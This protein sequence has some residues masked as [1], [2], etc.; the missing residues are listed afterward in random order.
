MKKR[1]ILLL[2]SLLLVSHSSI[3]YADFN[4]GDAVLSDIVTI[5]TEQEVDPDF[6]SGDEEVLADHDVSADDEEVP[7]DNGASVD[8]E[9]ISDDTTDVPSEESDVS[10]S[11]D[12]N[13]FSTGEDPVDD[14]SAELYEANESKYT[15]SFEVKGVFG[16]RNVTFNTNAPDGA[17]IYYSSTT[18]TLTTKDACVT[19]GETVLFEDFYGTIYART[20]VNGTWGTVSRL[21]LRIPVV[22]D[23]EIQVNGA[24]VTITTPTPQCFIYYTT[25]GTTPSLTNGTRASGSK[26][27]F[28]V[29]ANTTVKA[30]AVRSCFTNSNVV[31][32]KIQL[33][34]PAF[35]VKGIFG[36]RNVTFSCND[37]NAVIY[38]SDKTS[39]LTTADK[40]V[41]SGQSVDFSNFYGSIY[42]RAYSD[43]K[44]SNVSRLILKIPVVNKPTITS[45][46]SAVT[47]RTTTPDSYICY[48]TDG[49]KPSLTNGTRVGSSYAV[50]Y[51]KTGQQIRAIAIRS[52]FT[53]SEEASFVYTSYPLAQNVSGSGRDERKMNFGVSTA[54]W[55]SPSKS[56]LYGENNKLIVVDYAASSNVI[57]IDTYDLYS[58]NLEGT[59]QISM[60]LPLFGGFYSGEKYN[61]I[62]FGQENREQN[63]SKEVV[64]VVKYDK[65][66]KKIS[67]LSV[68][69]GESYTVEP[70]HAGNLSMSEYGNELTIHTG[71]LRYRTADGLNHQSQL[72]LLVNTD[73]MKLKETIETFQAN[74]VSHSFNQRVRYDNG[75]QVLVDHGDAYPRSVVLNKRNAEAISWSQKYTE[76]SLFKIPGAAGANCTGVTLGGFEIS[77]SSY[78]VAIN[79]IDHSKVTNY[80]SF[81]MVGLDKDE[82][83]VIIL[84][85]A[86]DNNSTDDVKQVKLTNYVNKGLLA[87]TPYL[88]KISDN[89]FAVLWEEFQYTSN[90]NMNDNGVKYVIIDGKGN[91]VTDVKSQSDIHL[92][93]DCQ[94]IAVNG[95][96]MW[97]INSSAGRTF[98][99]VEVSE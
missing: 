62:V 63:D 54:R 52:C 25:D 20:Y 21:I 39:S 50:V 66:F 64:R 24:E 96:I 78:L 58:R 69:G 43:G 80:T 27:V 37:P 17:K 89:R 23:P 35:T 93:S 99:S 38:Y 86:K 5:D 81:E 56:F 60:E 10:E 14:G 83:D 94:P 40:H 11:Q 31:E 65:N 1:F 57:N 28:K 41:K 53:N 95:Y 76:V 46:G 84:V 73:T 87:S 77:D 68:T 2:M 36:G 75:T 48:T 97:Y 79:S 51:P 91:K 18:S 90:Y 16:G 98:Y 82:R 88:V 3:A 55:S 33:S 92:S 70:F 67:T 42:A 49:S 12:L 59:K 47:I 30:I 74:H 32:Q 8:D 15:V 34:A 72:T 7:E 71:R 19:K 22:K 45:S 85:S 13:D 44:W 61:Y 9:E 26:A 4:E 29:N 6:V